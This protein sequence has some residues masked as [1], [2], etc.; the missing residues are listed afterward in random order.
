MSN[1]RLSS[2]QVNEFFCS[3]VWA[4]IQERTEFELRTLEVQIENGDPFQ[5]GIAVGQRRALKVLLAYQERLV[6]E[7]KGVNDHVRLD[8]GRIA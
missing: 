6:S 8:K 7:A 3:P 5:H 1:H 4:V 2:S